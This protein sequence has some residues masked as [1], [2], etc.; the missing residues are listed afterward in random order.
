MGTDRTLGLKG[1]QGGTTGFRVDADSRRRVL[2]PL[3][4]TLRRVRIE[5]P[6]HAAQPLCDVSPTFWTTCPEFRSAEI[7]RWM[8]KRGDKPWPPGSPPTY[9]AELVMAAGDTVTIRVLE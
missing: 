1:W 8:T 9:E 6:G 2:Q 4:R 3:K 5:L 7:G